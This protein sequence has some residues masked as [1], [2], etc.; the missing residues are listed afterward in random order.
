MLRILEHLLALGTKRLDPLEDRVHVVHVEVEMHGAP[1]T[2]VPA[3]VVR[4]G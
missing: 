2:L 1:V 3:A 4:L